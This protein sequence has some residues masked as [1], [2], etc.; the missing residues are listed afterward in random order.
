M[1]TYKKWIIAIV[2]I[3][4][5]ILLSALLFMLGWNWLIRPTG[6]FNTTIT[7][8]N[9]VAI[10]A[11]VSILYAGKKQGKQYDVDDPEAYLMIFATYVTKCVY[12]IIAFV[13][14]TLL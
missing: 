7:Y 14:S 11:F 9:W 8:S 10:S 2:V 6:L 5:D 3:V 12:L 1:R 13:I 4:V